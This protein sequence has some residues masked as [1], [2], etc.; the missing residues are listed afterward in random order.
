MNVFSPIFLYKLRDQHN[1]D[2]DQIKR[3]YGVKME[4]Y[5]KVYIRHTVHCI[6]VL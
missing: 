5:D 4:E 3:Y 6:H 1:Q 2:V